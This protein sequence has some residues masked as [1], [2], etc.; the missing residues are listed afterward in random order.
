MSE[1]YKYDV[2]FSC[3]EEDLPVA[4][5]IAASFREYGISY[6]LY[7]EHLA[8]HLG[9]DIFR[10]SLDKYE[11]EARYF[12][13]L[14]SETYV[15]KHWSNIERQIA[16]T[17]K[18]NGE[19]Y[20]LPIHIGENVPKVDGLGENIVYLKWKN[21]PAEIARLIVEKKKNKP[22]KD[23]ANRQEGNAAAT[24]IITN[25][26]DKIVSVVGKVDNINM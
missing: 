10:I 8:E 24:A 9:E 12:L 18:R 15:K 7:T 23:E 21:D 13:M 26:A 1:E 5:Q 19:A 16:Q 3:A 20:I 2:A 25:N 17:V 11:S 4:Q 22:E 6:Y 14:V